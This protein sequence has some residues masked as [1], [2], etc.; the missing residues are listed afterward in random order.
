MAPVRRLSKKEINLL[1]RP[2]IT[3]GILNSI[4]D[5]DKKYKEFVKE[6]DVTK[7]KEIYD[8]YKTKRNMTLALIWKSK[9]DYYAKILEENKS[10]IK[11]TWEG[12]HKVINITNKSRTIPPQLRYKNK[13]HCGNESMAESFNYFFT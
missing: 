7:K 2:C 1:E 8:F 4:Y 6:N 13:T 5:R 9:A 12:I 10:D 3:N 11:K